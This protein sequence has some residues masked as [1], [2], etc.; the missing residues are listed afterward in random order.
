MAEVIA[1]HPSL[2]PVVRAAMALGVAIS[3]VAVGATPAQK[4][5]IVG[6]LALV[7]ALLAVWAK[8]RRGKGPQS[9]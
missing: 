8:K 7:F 3:T 1:K 6:F 5:A 4:M 2:K 9:T